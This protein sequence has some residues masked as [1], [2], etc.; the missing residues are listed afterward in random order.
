[1]QAIMNRA[2]YMCSEATVLDVRGSTATVEVNRAGACETCLQKGSCPPPLE[3]ER[4]VVTV[5]DNPVGA[6]QGDTVELAI[7][8]SVVLWGAITVYM[9]P[10]A[11]LVAGVILA[12]YLNRSLGFDFPQA[13]FDMALGVVGLILGLILVRVI[14]THWKHLSIPRPEITRIITRAD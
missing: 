11:C 1:M 8:D 7:N 10:L 14:S 2:D 12:E 9:V 13:G 3:G 6:R 5:A 4:H